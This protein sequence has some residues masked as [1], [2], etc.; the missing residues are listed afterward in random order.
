[1]GKFIFLGFLILLYGGSILDKNKK[2]GN[3]D[4]KVENKGRGTI[5]LGVLIMVISVINGLL[6]SILP[7]QQ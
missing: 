4:K 6:S 2:S 1:M 7:I 5:V 3:N